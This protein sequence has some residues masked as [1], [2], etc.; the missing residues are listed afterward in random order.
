MLRTVDNAKLERGK[1]VEFG[2]QSYLILEA[3]IEVEW[4]NNEYDIDL[5]VKKI[6][7]NKEGCNGNLEKLGRVKGQYCCKDCHAP[8]YLDENGNLEA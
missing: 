2:E 1:V 7:C 8:V 5:T 4:G 6:S 3:E